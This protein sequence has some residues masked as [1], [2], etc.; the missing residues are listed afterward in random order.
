MRFLYFIE[1]VI[2]RCIS[3]LHTHFVAM[4][5]HNVKIGRNSIVYY[6][7][8]IINLSR[9]GGGIIIGYDC[10]IGCSPKRYHAGMP[11]YTRLLSD[12][13]NSTIVI[14]N[15][16]RING[17]SI[18]SG[19][20][21]EIG[22]NC[23][24]A[25]GV[26]IMDSNGHEVYS[27]NRTIGSDKPQPI[28]IGNNVWIGLNAVILKGTTIGDNC[29]IAVGSVVKGAFPENSLIAGNP[30]VVVKRIIFDE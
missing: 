22:N 7:S 23:V 24:I 25:S 18:H 14:G 20:S 29:V 28:S 2:E 9:L 30:A 17:A 6:K 21:I 19:S 10:K 16:C 1:K 3:I 11:F 27:K 12:G 5:S 8:S 15:N 4:L 13:T 26:S